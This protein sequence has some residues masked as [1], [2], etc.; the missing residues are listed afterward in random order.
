MKD[1]ISLQTKAVQFNDVISNCIFS[2]KNGCEL[3]VNHGITHIIG[4]LKTLEENQSSLY[5]I[6]NGG[7]AAVASH[8]TN[9]FCNTA[10]LRA[11]T[12]HDTALL[13]C[14]TNDYGYENAYSM[15]IDRLAK[16]G[17]LLVAISSSG[18][19]INIR[20]AV[21]SMQ[22]IGGNVLTLS[23]FSPNNKLRSLG[24][25]N[26]WLNTEAYGLAEIGHLFILHYLAD[27]FAIDRSS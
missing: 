11:N 10:G 25:I 3:S 17:D 5:L 19:S 23:G 15:L 26:I 16:V 12:I 18:M 24:D 13:T 20:K 1:T 7:S 22:A 4:L 9:D 8:M 14:Y 27:R 2:D 6:G 21:A